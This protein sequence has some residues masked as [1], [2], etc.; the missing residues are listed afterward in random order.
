MK[1]FRPAND[2]NQHVCLR[3]KDKKTQDLRNGYT[4]L[5]AHLNK[6]QLS[7]N[8]D[9]LTDS[10]MEGVFTF[11]ENLQTIHSFVNQWSFVQC[12]LKIHLFKTI[13]IF[14]SW[15]YCTKI[16]I[17]VEGTSKI[18]MMDVSPKIVLLY[19]GTQLWLSAN[20]IYSSF[21]GM[22]VGWGKW[23]PI[24]TKWFEL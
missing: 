2:P 1:Y 3:C 6:G 7:W 17:I 10:T 5:T 12:F 22:L 9:L 4:N 13:F 24:S 23:V 16:A 20:R 11:S 15:E 18:A 19:H 8:E 14:Y 21:T